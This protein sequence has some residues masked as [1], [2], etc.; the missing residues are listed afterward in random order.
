M[1]CLSA[2]ETVCYSLERGIGQARDFE[3]ICHD[4]Q[5]F[6][7]DAL[8]SEGDSRLRQDF[9]LTQVGARAMNWPDQLQQSRAQRHT[10]CDD[11]GEYAQPSDRSVPL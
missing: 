6:G 1:V 2:D 7:I 8:F 4:V 9:G 10:V 11:D 3:E 5:W